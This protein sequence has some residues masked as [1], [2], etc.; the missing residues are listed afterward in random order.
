M[1]MESYLFKNGKKF[2]PKNNRKLIYQVDDLNMSQV[3]IY[4]T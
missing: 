3:D 2:G 1:I 4:G